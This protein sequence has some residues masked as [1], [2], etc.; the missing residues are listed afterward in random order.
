[1]SVLVLV[2]HDRGTLSPA[3][4]EA[5]AAARGV[6]SELARTLGQN[7][8]GI[9]R[10]PGVLLARARASRTADIQAWFAALWSALRPHALGRAAVVPRLWA[11]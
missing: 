7:N 11:T 2:E 6:G 5:L 10:V 9:T 4:L 1:M 3:T 8:A